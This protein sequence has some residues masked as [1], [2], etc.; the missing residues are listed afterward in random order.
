M[1]RF[2]GVAIFLRLV[3][4]V[5]GHEMTFFL[6]SGDFEVVAISQ[7]VIGNCP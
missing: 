3:F 5:V 6:I 1:R 2:G 4:L 7:I